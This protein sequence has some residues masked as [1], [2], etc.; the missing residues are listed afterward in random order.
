M[1]P[2]NKM[3]QRYCA[4]RYTF[5]P[6]TFGARPWEV[7]STG[8]PPPDASP[9]WAETW[10]KSQALRRMIILELRK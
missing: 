6:W 9:Y 2:T 5:E 3:V 10:R 1:T 4:D 8:S 7:P